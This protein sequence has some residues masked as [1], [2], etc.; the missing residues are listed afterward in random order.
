MNNTEAT[1]HESSERAQSI[2]ARDRALDE[3]AAAN[4]R[5]MEKNHALA[6]ALSRA[7]KELTKAKAQLTQMTQP[8]KSFGTM[9]RVDSSM[10]DDQGVQH[11]SAEVM[12]GTRRLIVPVAATVNAAR[13]AA[14]ATVL[15][16]ENMVLVEQRGADTLGPVRTIRQL[17]DDGRLI[18]V[19]GGGNPSVVRRASAMAHVTCVPGQRVILDASGRF[20]VEMLPDEDN[21]DLVLEEVPD[22]TFADIGGLEDQIERIRDAV[23]LPFLHRSLYERY[24]LKAPKGVLLYGPPGNGKTMIAKAVAH[25]LSQGFG[26]GAGVFL[27][28]KGPELLNK[29]VGESER[30]IRQ[31][32][33]RARERA[34]D[35]RPVIVFIDEMDSLLRTRGSGVSS[36]METTIVP[37]FLS[38]LDGVESLDNVMVIGASNRVDMID[39]AVLRPGRLDVKIRVD[40][41]DAAHAASVIRHY[42]TD[43]LPLEEGVDAGD[44][45]KVLVRDVYTRSSRRHLCDVCNDQGQW[46]AVF[47]ADVA[48]GA[49][50][51]N[52]VDRA[53]TKAVK[54][55]IDNGAAVAITTELLGRA[56]EDEFL[57]TRDSVV[58]ADPQQWSRINGMEAGRVTRIRP[59]TRKE[60][61]EQAA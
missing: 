61:K 24:D 54:A 50:L 42:L 10:I 52:I 30:L 40:R 6:Q 26:K 2:E 22:V 53:K 5:L 8:P 57:E 51:K 58:D 14:G 27:S 46:S 11:A 31:I 1:V 18:I 44:L 41:P 38:E 28:V 17:L 9:I 33:K 32:F 39:P 15:L 12:M 56:V 13:L 47:L 23:Q 21:T 49:M 35:G 4:D 19:D 3:L 36:D 37:Q 60:S 29:F 55:S 7:G 59:V 43:D 48:S 16:N 45:S 34:A 25:A 20:A